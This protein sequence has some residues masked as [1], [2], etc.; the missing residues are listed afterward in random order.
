FEQTSNSF[1][2]AN[3]GWLAA[4]ANGGSKIL[5]FLDSLE[6]G[7]KQR[8]TLEAGFITLVGATAGVVR[9]FQLAQS[10]LNAIAA[11]NGVQGLPGAP[12][13]PGAPGDKASKAFKFLTY[14]PIVGEAAYSYLQWLTEN[15][16]KNVDAQ[17][18]N[19]SPNIVN[20]GR[21]GSRLGDRGP[22]SITD[23]FGA[24]AYGGNEYLDDLALWRR[25]DG[26]ED[27]LRSGGNQPNQYGGRGRGDGAGW[28]D[29]IHAVPKSDGFKDVNVQGTVTG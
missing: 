16:Q 27:F 26:T 18:K 4:A 29:S 24:S 6:E 5:Q 1:V 17:T 25:K 11:K 14:A 10:T 2:K 20:M 15:N 3:E 13:A 12:G 28:T 19:P 7:K 23:G 9:A 8:L 21:I 22:I